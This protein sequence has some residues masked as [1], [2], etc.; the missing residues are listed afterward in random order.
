MKGPVLGMV[1][2]PISFWGVLFCFF[3]FLGWLLPPLP[4]PAHL[5]WLWEYQDEWGVRPGFRER[6]EGGARGS[7]F[8]P[9]RLTGHAAGISDQ[10]YCCFC[11]FCLLFF[12][13]LLR[14]CDWACRLTSLLLCCWEALS[15]CVPSQY[16]RTLSFPA[17][18]CLSPLSPDP[19]ASQRH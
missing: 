14:H 16:P 9:G 3:L 8:L 2:Y 5:P 6:D 18:G 19:G 11:G 12:F 17:G 1:C 10:G 15:Q 7:P 4:L 13:L